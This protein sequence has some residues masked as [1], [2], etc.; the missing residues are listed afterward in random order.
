MG[1]WDHTFYQGTHNSVFFLTKEWKMLWA[2]QK[3][4]AC[5]FN[6]VSYFQAVWCMQA[7]EIF[8]ALISSLKLTVCDVVK[9]N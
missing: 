8:Y 3:S 7:T 6:Y 2:K 4:I 5:W 1:N 9:I